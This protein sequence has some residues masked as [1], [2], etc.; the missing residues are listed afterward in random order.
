[1]IA[2]DLNGDGFPEVALENG[3]DVSFFNLL[4]FGG[5]AYTTGD[6]LRE[7]SP[8]TSMAM[9]RRTFLRYPITPFSE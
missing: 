6:G 7:W 5:L 8:E 2:A 1:M 9:G 3:P 4:G